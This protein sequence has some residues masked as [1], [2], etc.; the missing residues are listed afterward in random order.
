MQ[1]ALLIPNPFHVLQ[2]HLLTAAV[3]KFRGS[4]VGVASDGLRDLQSSSILQ[5]VGDAGGPER[6]GE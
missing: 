5:V 4:A 2:E 1:P 3:R 6:T